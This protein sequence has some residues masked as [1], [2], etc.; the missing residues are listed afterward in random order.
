M[1]FTVPAR[2]WVPTSWVI[3]RRSTARG[4]IVIQAARIERLE[5]IVKSFIKPGM[6]DQKR[7]EALRLAGP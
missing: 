3:R 1:A 2:T 7:A 5:N 6:S 4:Q